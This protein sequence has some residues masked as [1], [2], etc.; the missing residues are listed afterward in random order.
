MNNLC[1]SSPD[2]IKKMV[3]DKFNQDSLNENARLLE[4]IAKQ[5]YLLDQVDKRQKAFDAWLE[6][7]ELILDKLSLMTGDIPCMGGFYVY[8]ASIVFYGFDTDSPRLAIYGALYGAPGLIAKGFLGHHHWELNGT[9]I[10][11]EKELILGKPNYVH[12]LINA[13]VTDHSTPTT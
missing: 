12:L 11:V 4:L 10:E 8:H 5:K 13:R 3:Y 2:Q 1:I 7:N 9:P 6:D